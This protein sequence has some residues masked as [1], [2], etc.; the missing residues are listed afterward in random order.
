M[1][2]PPK[3]WNVVADESSDTAE[4]VLYG[5]IVS[6]QPVDFWTGQA[7]E[8]N[9]ITPEGFLDDL[10]KCKGKNNLTIRLNSCGGDLF[11]GIAIH[12]ALKGFNGKKTV[13]VEGIAAS[14][15]SVIAC[16][17]DEVQVYPGSITMIHG[18]STFVFDALNLSDMKKMVKAMDSM[19]NAIAA[20]YSA[21]T[22]KEVGELRNLI[23][24]E[25]WMTGQEAID[26]GFAD[27]LIDG[28]VA[29]KLQLVAS[30]SGKFVLK[31]GGH[32]LSSDFRAAIPDRFHVA[33]INSV[34][35][36]Q[37]AEG[38]S[39]EDDLQAKLLQAEQEL[40]AAKSE[41]A[42]LQEKM[43]TSQEPDAKAKEEIIAQAIAEERKRLSDIE[44]I[45]NGIDP[46]LVQDAKFGETPMTAQE[47]AFR[48]MSSG[49]FSG[50]NFLNSRAADLQDSNTGR[51]TIAPTGNEAGGNY[52]S[53]LAE[54][55]KAANESTKT[56]K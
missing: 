20:I 10:S 51:V 9:Y 19:E 18:V 43:A 33:V 41:L 16:A 55:I 29:N 12:N 15:A 37:T 30:A 34:Q 35:S 52:T 1:N 13:I 40:A 17:G 39:S 56:K 22:G 4:I 49:K 47:L 8:G 23:T 50:A 11:T 3:F 25:T 44:A 14:A 48:A 7:I 32:V 53:R 36:E 42:A 28:E 38:D 6:Q 54:A 31:A 5:D 45:A 24:R 27:T 46:E 21:K 26:N 2:T